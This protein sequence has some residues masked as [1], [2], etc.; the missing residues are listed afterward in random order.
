M[1]LSI[2]IFPFLSF[3]ST[4]IFGRYIGIF[5][6]NVLSTFSIAFSFTLAIFIFYESAI[7]GS[8][9]TILLAPWINTELFISFWGFYFDAVSSLM[10][11]VV[12]S[13]SSLVHLYATEYMSADPHQGR[14]M[15]YL[16]LFYWFYANSSNRW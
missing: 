16:S 1:Y 4:N 3:F 8:V 14:F 12:C 15:G 2:L 11:L 7:C 5:G 6:S 10:L 13:V 9:C